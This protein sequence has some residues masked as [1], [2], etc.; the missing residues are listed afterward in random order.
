MS[1]PHVRWE[2]PRSQ[3]LASTPAARERGAAPGDVSARIV[4]LLLIACTAVAVLDL[5]LL[6]ASA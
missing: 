1:G 5:Y 2:P 3:T 4:L 6:Y